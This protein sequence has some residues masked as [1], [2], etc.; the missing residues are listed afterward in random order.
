MAPAIDRAPLA[1]VDRTEEGA[2]K[3][4]SI[5]WWASY[6]RLPYHRV[7]NAAKLCALKT[8]STDDDLQR[9]L[10]VLQHRAVPFTILGLLYGADLPLY[11]LAKNEKLP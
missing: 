3:H 9:I 7:Y 6:L 10:A 5:H 1:R 4:S 8:I 11:E 2:F